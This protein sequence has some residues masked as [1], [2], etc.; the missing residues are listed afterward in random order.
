MNKIRALLQLIFNFIYGVLWSG[1]DTARFI[2]RQPNT[3][4]GLTRMDY[5]QLSP[6]AASILAAL[7]TLTP[8]TTAVSIDR[9]KHQFV[10]HLLDLKQSEQVFHSIHQHF[11]IPLTVLM[12][13]HR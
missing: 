6:S 5:G 12:G 13:E 3:A 7:V 1:W 10:L 4:G 11:I 8:G 2:V 9:E